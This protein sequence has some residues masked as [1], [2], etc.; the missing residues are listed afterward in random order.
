MCRSSLVLS[1]VGLLILPSARLQAENAD[2]VL[3][4]CEVLLRDVKPAGGEYAYIPP[5]GLLCWHYIQAIR[6]LAHIIETDTKRRTLRVCP[7]PGTTGLQWVRIYTEYAHRNPERL[8]VSA[9]AV[10]MLAFWQSFP[11]KD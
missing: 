7:P 9:G 1:L 4:S 6:D 5:D 8:N 10:A 3:L 11:C 2:K